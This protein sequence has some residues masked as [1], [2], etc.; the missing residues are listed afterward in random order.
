MPD[1]AEEREGAQQYIEVFRRLNLD[2][3]MSERLD[4]IEKSLVAEGP[5]A[6][7]RP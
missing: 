4:A 5:E 1:T 7:A 6:S 3:V 2:A